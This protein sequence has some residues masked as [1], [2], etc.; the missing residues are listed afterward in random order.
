MILVNSPQ[1]EQRGQGSYEVGYPLECASITCQLAEG[2]NPD[3]AASKVTASFPAGTWVTEIINFLT[4]GV[5]NYFLAVPDFVV[6]EYN[7]DDAERYSALREVLPGQYGWIIKTDPAGVLQ[8]SQWAMPEIGGASQKTLNMISKALTP[9]ANTLYTQVEIR[10]YNQQD[11]TSG[12]ILEVV[13]N[14]DGTGTIYGSSVPWTT[15]FNIFDS[16]DSP[17]PSLLI[18]GGTVEEPEVEDTDVEFVDYTAILSK[19][20]Y[21]TPVIDWGK[22]DSLS[23]ISY[24]ESGALTTATDPGYSVAA[25]VTFLSRRKKWKYN[26]KKVDIT[27]VRLKYN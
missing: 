8:L 20:C 19:P 17:A 12:L 16:E 23:P 6:G 10:N 9:P 5:C 14:G 3:I 25:K 26:N 15:A 13:D 7:F 22:N 4:A 21:S 27:Q 18:T 11:G 24:T 2:L 1:D